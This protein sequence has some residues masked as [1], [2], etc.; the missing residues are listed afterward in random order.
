MK[1]FIDRN[2]Y[3]VLNPLY[4]EEYQ[5]QIN[6]LWKEVIRLNSLIFILEKIKDFP[7]NPL[8]SYNERGPFWPLVVDIF[9]RESILIT[10]RIVVDSEPEAQTLPKLKNNIVRNICDD[11]YRLY[12]RQELGK[13]NF[14]KSIKEIKKRIENLRN[15][16]LAHLS[17]KNFSEKIEEKMR[18]SYV[19]LNEVI[20]LRDK[21]NEFFS[22][23][24]L[25]VD[26]GL[27][28]P[29]YSISNN[30]NNQCDIDKI[31]YLL[32][33]NSHVLNM[34]EAQPEYWLYFRKSL[35]TEHLE[36]IN[37]SRKKLGLPKA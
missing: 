24:S 31:L 33:K 10:Y 36:K 2:E 22:I 9:F 27:L 21:I 35:D 28:H 29:S 7:F 26:R 23:L 3:E 12:F 32:A 5:L 30:P 1:D 25:G 19:R 8:L 17:N 20:E 37:N 16:R 11:D 15:T 6:N 13:L 14:E 34:P 4:V 18:N